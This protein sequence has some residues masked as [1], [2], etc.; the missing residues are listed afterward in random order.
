MSKRPLWEKI[1]IF[2]VA[3]VLN[4]LVF[5]IPL[6]WVLLLYSAMP[7]YLTFIKLVLILAFS[8]LALKSVTVS[9]LYVFHDIPI[10]KED[11]DV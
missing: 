10:K 2:L 5:G 6:V 9:Y 7:E 8:Y 1:A 4:L 3:A 11:R